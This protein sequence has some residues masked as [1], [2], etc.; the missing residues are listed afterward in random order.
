ML[1]FIIYYS[2]IG[3]I[4]S[5]ILNITLWALHKPVLTGWEIIACS[6]LWPTTINSLITSFNNIEE[7]IE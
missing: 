6:V 5:I 3:F 1:N 2:A 4:L 7:D